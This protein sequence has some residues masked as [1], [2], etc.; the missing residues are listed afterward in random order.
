MN[1][2]AHAWTLGPEAPPEV[3]LGVALPDLAG[4]HDRRAPRVALE[5][6]SRFEEEGAPLLARGVRAH[7]A[8][9]SCFHELPAFKE[10]CSAIRGELAKLPLESVRGFFLAHLLL[11]VLLD[12]ALLEGDPTLVT[13]FYEAIETSPREK[14]ARLVSSKDA[15]GLERWIDRFL[16]AR[17]LNDYATDEGL[18][19]RVEQVLNRA[20]QTLGEEG[21]RRLRGALGPLRERVRA[22]TAALTAEPRAAVQRVLG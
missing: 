4:V 15:P 20:R 21:G 16:R 8:A 2:L 22:R 5:V 9:D 1:F 18:V 17:F 10:E 13:R 19:F 6:A 14:A 7:H 12:A 11:E 3:V